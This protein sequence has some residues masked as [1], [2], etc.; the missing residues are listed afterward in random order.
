MDKIAA[1]FLRTF[2]EKLVLFW[3]LLLFIVITYRYFFGGG[4]PITIDGPLFYATGALSVAASV[5]LA[6]PRKK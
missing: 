3:A 1:G 2:F 5:Y 4:L 6:I